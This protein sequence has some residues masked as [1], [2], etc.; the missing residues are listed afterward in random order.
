MDN[1]EKSAIIVYKNSFNKI[2]KNDQM[3][4]GNKTNAYFQY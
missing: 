4:A 1:V 2:P 3:I